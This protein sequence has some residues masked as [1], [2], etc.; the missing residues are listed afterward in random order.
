M[1]LQLTTDDYN[2]F[3]Q[4]KINS[5]NLN[6]LEIKIKGGPSDDA[7]KKLEII[8]SEIIRIFPEL[9][10]LRQDCLR[11]ILS[12]SFKDR[13]AD[14]FQ[15]LDRLNQLV[16][17]LQGFVSEKTQSDASATSSNY[18]NTTSLLMAI[19]QAKWQLKKIAYDKIPN[20]I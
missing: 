16:E 20:H 13:S 12:K 17:I 6:R 1:E 19:T 10:R 14:L 11:L 8:E 3:A 9:S 18:G 7:G 4:A 2:I 15:T 5:I